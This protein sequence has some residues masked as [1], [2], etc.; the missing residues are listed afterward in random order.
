MS[1]F[2]GKGDKMALFDS[3]T[4]GFTKIGEV[5]KS[6]LTIII[7]CVFLGVAWQGWQAFNKYKANQ[8][9]ALKSKDDQ[10]KAE[11]K[12]LSDK[13]ASLTQEK[14]VIATRNVVL[15]AEVESARVKASNNPPPK[16]VSDTPADVNQVV[17][18]I[19]QSGVVFTLT[20][21]TLGLDPKLGSATTPTKNLPTVWTWYRE[22][23]RVPQLETA[24]SSQL[25]LT[26]ALTSEVGGLK[27][28]INKSNELIAKHVETEA[29]HIEREA[30]LDLIVKDTTAQVKRERFNGY[31]KA[32]V[33]AV[34]SFYV[35]KGVAKK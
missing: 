33:A 3:V 7:I 8:I 12:I 25:G 22:S 29:K 13:L 17:T 4:A 27:L 10:H 1:E 5:V 18:E 14:A 32:G 16:P 23:Q 6:Y 34:L 15:E 11:L 28:E 30:N 19:A 21:P 2:W 9:A 31:V 24:Y 35:G 26:T 20:V